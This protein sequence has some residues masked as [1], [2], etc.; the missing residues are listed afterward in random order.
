MKQLIF[1][2][3]FSTIVFSQNYQYAIEE[4]PVKTPETPSGINN[5][6]EEIEYFKAYLLPIAQKA[7]LQAALNTYGSVRLEQGDYSGADIVMKSNQRLYGHPTL[8]KVPNVTIAA[9][10]TNVRLEQLSFVD[11]TVT[12]EAGAAISNCIFKTL[13]YVYIK[14]IGAKLENNELINIGGQIKFD[15]SLS[16]Y[17]RN[18]KII[19]HQA[20]TISNQLVMKGNTT[21]PSYGNVNLHSNY[22]TPVGDATDID[23]LQS[24]TFVGVDSEGWNLNGEGSRAMFYAKNMGDFKI[25]DFGG[26]NS[27]SAV[28]TGSYDIDAK[29]LLFFNK[30]LRTSNDIISART[31]IFL[32]D[33]EGGY[34]RGSGTITGFD[35]LGNLDHSNV[36]KY[37]GAEQ[38]GTITNSSTVA[39]ISS[40]ILGTKYTPWARPAWETIPDPLGA[41][42]KANRTGKP[43]QRAYIQN[44]IDTKGIA[45]LPEGIFY[46]SSTLNIHL[47]GNHGIT[48]QGTGKTVIVGL[49]DDFPLLTLDTGT[50]TNFIL[51]HLTLQGGKVGIYAGKKNNLGIGQIAYEN[52]KFIVFRDQMYGFQLSQIMGL[53]NSFFDHVGFVNCSKGF[54][55]EPL[56]PYAGDYNTSS[57][58]DKTMYYR[59]QFINCETAISML[60]TRPDNLNAWVECKFDRGQTA[61]NMGGQN[62]P[63]IANCDFSNY[64]GESVINS[65]S[66]S[67]YSCNF[68]NNNPSASTFKSMITYIEGS[69]FSDNSKMFSPVV[70]NSTF[71]YIMNSKITGDVVVPKPSSMYYDYSGIYVNSTLASNPALSKLLV[72]VKA[73]VPAVIINNLPD[74]YPQLLVTQ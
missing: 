18:N 62:Y 65:N 37:N 26:A 40:T 22:L 64:N 73:G 43:D 54:F 39:T 61:L 44:L 59:S 6:L 46:I 60:A 53:D 74:P 7:N 20:Q 45:E 9:G 67:I 69:T 15:C 28:Q 27:Y 24:A 21:T 68:Y 4:A 41:N 56:L 58:V 30:Y 13:R 17:F 66:V 19:K 49:T 52:L 12:F 2:L 31:N 32:V 48:G 10:S 23:A 14:A 29:N 34:K 50:D 8:T 55:K 70:Y 35:L 11:R 71:H 33:G 47:D 72:N 5:Q 63:I 1:F 57:Y 38:T 25:T 42:W 36:V 16:G 51:T 3:F